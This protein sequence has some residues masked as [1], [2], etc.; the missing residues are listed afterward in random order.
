[1]YLEDHLY[2]IVN[3]MLLNA[4]Y[5]NVANQTQELCSPERK[6]EIKKKETFRFITKYFISGGVVNYVF[7]F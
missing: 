1:M 4:N 6:R 7:A 2:M 5:R 3:N